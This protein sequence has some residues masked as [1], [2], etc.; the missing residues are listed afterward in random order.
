[1]IRWQN[2]DLWHPSRGGEK[3]MDLAYLN[4]ILKSDAFPPFDPWFAGGYMNY[5]Y[6]G[7]VLV[8]T[9]VKLTGVMPAVA[10]NLAIAYLLR[11]DRGRGVHSDG[12][13]RAGRHPRRGPS[14]RLVGGESFPFVWGVLGALFVAVIG[15]LY[16]VRLVLEQPPALEP[17]GVRHAHPVSAAGRSSPARFGAGDD[18]A[19]PPIEL[20]TSGTGTQ[21]G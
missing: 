17:A 12:R 13:T 6:F 3:P 10:Y 1:M 18:P 9:L 15:N 14:G 20:P 4:A 8:A 7:F 21:P 5:Y 19:W 11:L 2:P 16:E